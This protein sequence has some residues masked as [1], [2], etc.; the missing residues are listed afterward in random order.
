MTTIAMVA[1]MV[2]SAL[3]VGAGGEFRSPMAIAVIG[4]LLFSTILS[5]IF[6]PAVFC[7]MCVISDLPK[8]LYRG[9]AARTGR[10]RAGRSKSKDAAAGEAPPGGLATPGE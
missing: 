8:R 9:V 4:G 2:P 3:A 7:L 10:L 5:L 6:V 1:G